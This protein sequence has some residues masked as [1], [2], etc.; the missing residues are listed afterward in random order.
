[1]ELWRLIAFFA[2][3]FFAFYAGF[4]LNIEKVMFVRIL[5]RFFFE[6]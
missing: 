3:I 2:F 5:S 4:D 1:M 6:K